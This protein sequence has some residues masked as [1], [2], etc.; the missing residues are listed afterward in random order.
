LNGLAAAIHSGMRFVDVW[1]VAP[2]EAR[3]FNGAMCSMRSNAFWLRRL[4]H[5]L[6]RPVAGYVTG[7]RHPFALWDWWPQL[8]ALAGLAPAE[9]SLPAAHVLFHG[10]R[11]IPRA[12]YCRPRSNRVDAF[13]EHALTLR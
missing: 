5:V 4:A 1:S 10:G 13:V 12:S 11:P 9:S 8:L 2:S 3:E 6:D 7:L